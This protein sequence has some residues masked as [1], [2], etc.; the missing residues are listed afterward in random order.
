MAYY[1]FYKWKK[2]NG[3]GT[4]TGVSLIGTILSDVSYNTQADCEATLPWQ[5][6]DIVL[7]NVVGT[8]TLLQ[9]YTQWNQDISAFENLGS[10]WDYSSIG[11]K[12]F[13]FKSGTTFQW[14]Y[15]DFF[16][17]S[18]D[19]IIHSATSLTTK[20]F[21]PEY[22]T[23]ELPTYLNASDSSLTWVYKPVSADYPA[24]YNSNYPNSA[25]PLSVATGTSLGMKIG[26]VWL[27]DQ[28]TVYWTEGSSKNAA[29]WFV[30]KMEMDWT[31][32]T[33]TVTRYELNHLPLPYQYVHTY[34]VNHATGMVNIL[35]L[36]N[37]SDHEVKMWTL[38]FNTHT[39][40]NTGHK[41]TG[42]YTDE[43]ALGTYA[44][45]LNYYSPAN[46]NIIFVRN[47]DSSSTGS[48][49][50][51]YIDPVNKKYIRYQTNERYLYKYS[52]VNGTAVNINDRFI[53]G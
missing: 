20:Y 35:A 52:A 41:V 2:Y 8:Y 24:V 48:Q 37:A 47:N 22:V 28:N 39:L 16:D 34:S 43:R 10:G 53:N 9:Y 42:F 50:R 14:I 13:G 44:D 18:T 27:K 49:T 38:D 31:N 32:N 12:S 23:D 40:T 21:T 26:L 7:T 30:S 5:P 11:N 46:D 6:G 45:T 15:R 3:D 19:S 4:N 29:I 33:S 51:Y 1:Q 25:F 36:E 17:G